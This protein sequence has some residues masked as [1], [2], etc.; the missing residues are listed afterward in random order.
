MPT[1][2]SPCRSARSTTPSY[3]GRIGIGRIF[4]GTMH[5]GERLLVIK[6]DGTRYETPIK[7][8]YTFEALGREEAESAHAG[9][10]VAVVGVEDADIGDML[11]CRLDPV[12]LD[13]IHVE[14]P[15]MSVVFAASTSPLVG[16]EGDIVGGRQLKERLLR[17]AESNISMRIAETED[18]TGMEVAG[19]GVLHLSV[20]METM[21][22]EGYEF[23]VGRPQVIFKKEG[24]KRLEPIELAVVDVPATTPAR[25]SRSSARAAAR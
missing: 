17:E 9:D 2:L 11:T 21:R 16:Q 23:Q 19:R 6:N 8:L 14:E 18:K 1:G 24:G 15:T 10:I 22:R 20:L 25:S 12:E 13:P 7:Q 4:S 3:V 5:S